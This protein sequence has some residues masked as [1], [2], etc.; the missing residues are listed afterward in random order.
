ML[1]CSSVLIFELIERLFFGLNLSS[2]FR[3]DH[4]FHEPV[5]G[6]LKV[7]ALYI[8]VSKESGWDNRL[9]F[10]FRDPF[11]WDISFMLR[12]DEPWMIEYL[13][14]SLQSIARIFNEQPVHKVRKF[15]RVW[16]SYLVWNCHWIIHY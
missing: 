1:K 14:G 10:F 4:G 11:D 3:T 5:I 13:I 16:H 9:L 6:P 8:V 2:R 12:I 7:E 15:I